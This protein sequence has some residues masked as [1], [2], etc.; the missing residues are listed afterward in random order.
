MGYHP[1]VVF[2]DEIKQFIIYGYGD[3]GPEIVTKEYLSS[4]CYESERLE[5]DGP[6]LL[7]EEIEDDLVALWIGD[8]FDDNC[9]IYGAPQPDII[10]EVPQMILHHAED[11]R[12][13]IASYRLIQEGL[14]FWIRETARIAMVERSKG[15][16][17]LLESVSPRSLDTL[18]AIYHTRSTEE[19]RGQEIDWFLRCDGLWVEDHRKELMDKRRQELIDKLMTRTKQIKGE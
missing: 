12:Y 11:G 3:E 19:E 16:A 10:A 14:S 5:V 4:M 17:E 1:I 15:L 8:D 2:S 9:T 18:A 13:G 7:R 6:E